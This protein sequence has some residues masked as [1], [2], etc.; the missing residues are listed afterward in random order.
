MYKDRLA[1]YE[2]LEQ[3]RNGKL[4]VYVTGDRRGLEAAIAR[5][6][7]DFFTHHL[8]RIGVQKRLILFLYTAGG[9]TL[10]AWSII[11]QLQIFTDWL[12]VIVPVK[13]H[14]AG[15]LI[16]LGADSIMMTKQATLSPI[17]PS[18]NGDL[19]PQIPGA[20][21]TAKAPVSVESVNGFIE[22]ARETLGKKADL[23]DIF[24]RL[25]ENV[26]PLVL[27]NA[28]RA[29]SQIRML[30]SRLLTRH[31][32]D[33]KQREKILEFLC[34]QSG[35]HDYTINRREA[36]DELGLKVEKPNDNQYNLI[37]EIY[38]DIAAELELTNRYEAKVEL[39]SADSKQYCFSRALI[40]SRKG[41]SHV[42]QSE[43]S[44][45]RKHIQV[46]PNIVQIAIQDDRSFEGWR[47]RDISD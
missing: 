22:F 23:K 18:V 41:G 24:L 8:D 12:E 6:V 37:K 16:C 32:S 29:R 19:N 30:A 4:L 28:F 25:A 35:S 45:T 11:N 33:E 3:D 17:D 36:K 26:H 44:L 7:I 15:T 9:D 1:L 47:Q 39:G 20:A 46:Q 38:K 31:N 27:G 40:E 10:A 43:G 5:D 42:F 14:S 2:Q 13:S 21:P 34:S